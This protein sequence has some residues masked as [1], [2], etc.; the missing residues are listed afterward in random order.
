MKRQLRKIIFLPAD[1]TVLTDS[2]FIGP[3][4]RK[5]YL[6]KIEKMAPWKRMFY[7]MTFRPLKEDVLDRENE[8][9][10]QGSIW[11]ALEHFKQFGYEVILYPHHEQ[12][13]SSDELMAK[14]DQFLEK[15]LAIAMIKGNT[16]ADF[17]Q[18]IPDF[19]INPINSIL[20][21]K[22]QQV[23]EKCLENFFPLNCYSENSPLLDK[24]LGFNMINWKSATSVRTEGHYLMSKSSLPYAL[25]DLIAPPNTIYSTGIFPFMNDTIVYIE[26]ERNEEI[27]NFI[28]ENFQWIQERFAEKGCRFV[29]FSKLTNDEPFFE[30]TSEYLRY[31]YPDNQTEFVQYLPSIQRQIKPADWGKLLLELLNLPAIKVPALIRGRGS[32]NGAKSNEFSYTAFDGDKSIKEQFEHYLNRLQPAYSD[33]YIIRHRIADLPDET[34]D[35]KFFSDTQE[36]SK[37]IIQKI[38]YLKSKGMYSLLAEIA[39]RLFDRDPLAVQ[40][41]LKTDDG[42]LEIKTHIAPTLSRLRIEWTS[43]FDFQIL[44]PD[45]GNLVV[46]MPRLPKALFYFFLQHPE[47]VMLNSLADYKDE[48]LAIY[49]RVSNKS[50]QSEIEKNI[51]RLVDP[52]D[53]SVNVNCS[54]IKNAFVKLI[55]DQLAQ[56]YYITGYRG[57]PKKIALPPASIEIVGAFA[58]GDQYH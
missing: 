37:D 46:E 25:W 5:V 53:N 14:V 23:M 2:G 48:L 27:N 58:I 10:F 35:D 12:S 42:K 44:L 9:N 4:Y 32:I 24:P 50:N 16:V 39:L 8:L 55:D 20:V 19:N 6:K 17:L 30:F 3:I 47:G 1:Q 28:D 34:A 21:L 57:E 56:N 51:E 13:L 38:E 15:N 7:W 45:Y 11:K 54:R 31:F 29:H 43:K 52:F 26:E 41:Q 33:A 18:A 22:D 40:E 49:K 36:L